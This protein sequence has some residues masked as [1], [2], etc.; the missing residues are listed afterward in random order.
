MIHISNFYIWNFSSQN[1][2]ENNENKKYKNKNVINPKGKFQIIIH[3]VV[4]EKSDLFYDPNGTANKLLNSSKNHGKSPGRT[5][6]PEEKAN[7]DDKTKNLEANFE[8]LEK[9]VINLEKIIS[10]YYLYLLFKSNN[11]RDKTPLILNKNHEGSN[12]YKKYEHISPSRDKASSKSAS[13]GFDKSKLK[14]NISVHLKKPI[15]PDSPLFRPRCEKHTSFA[16]YGYE[17]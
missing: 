8:L 14:K 7:K 1:P 17:L 12:I 6:K 16:V 4:S 9:K 10:E 5:E 15:N 13:I 2:F 3:F 11:K